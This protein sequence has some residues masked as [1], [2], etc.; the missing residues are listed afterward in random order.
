[1]AF[2]T[3]APEFFTNIISSF[4]VDSDVGLGGIFGS[5]MFN[6]LGV[7]AVAGM[8]TSNFKSNVWC[9][10]DWWP[11]T[12][13]CILYSFSILVL[14]CFTWDGQISLKES[15]VMVS[16]VSIYILALVFNKRIMYCMKWIMEINLN[17]CHLHSYGKYCCDSFSLFENIIELEP[18]V[19]Q[20]HIEPFL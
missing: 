10:L 20:I 18:L 3:I 17:C 2:A 6:V 11:L 12:R 9:Q 19:F 7:A 5:L 4:V 13:D 8:A 15:A 1:M 14:I 16:L